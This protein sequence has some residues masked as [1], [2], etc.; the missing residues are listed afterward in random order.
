MSAPPSMPPQSR[1][2]LDDSEL[3]QPANHRRKSRAAGPHCAAAEEGSFVAVLLMPAQA[4]VLG[5]QQRARSGAAKMTQTSKAK[6]PAL[7]SIP[8]INRGSTPRDCQSQTPL[9]VIFRPQLHLFDPYLPNARMQT[10]IVACPNTVV[11][12][13]STQAFHVIKTAPGFAV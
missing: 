7:P 3:R 12:R 5:D 1:F 6:H 9:T 13:T 2:G 10:Y 8:D 4:Q 11:T